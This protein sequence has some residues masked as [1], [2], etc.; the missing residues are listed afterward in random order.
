MLSARVARNRSLVLDVRSE[1][2][3]AAVAAAPLDRTAIPAE[4]RG[5]T[6]ERTPV[7]VLQIA[8]PWFTVPPSG[9]GGVET[10]VALLSDGLVAAGHEVELLASGGSRTTAKLRSVYERPPSELLGDVATDLG[11]VLDAY[12]DP[13]DVDLI[14]DHSGLIGP[15]LG[16][17]VGGVQVVHT[18]HGPWTDA[19]RHIYGRLA[20]RI[21][22]VAISNDQARRRPDGMPIAGMVHNTISLEHHP[23]VEERGDYLLWVGRA[24]RDK[25]PVDAIEVARRLGRPL[26]MAMKVNEAAEHVYYREVI[27]PAMIGVDVEVR[28]NVPLHAK[29]ALMGRASCLLFPI[30]WPEPFGLVMIESMACGTPVVAF[31]NGAAPEIIADGRT[32][33]LVPEGDID[34]FCTAVRASEMIHP[35]TCR[36]H[37]EEHFSMQRMV[38]GYL[39]VYER[40]LDRGPSA[41][42]GDATLNRAG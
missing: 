5:V 23:L 8:P 25:G 7:R 35:R 11:Q 3:P 24:N 4:R 38:D 21:G 16:A 26:V 14:H 28:F 32:G 12:L 15:A 2:V 34:A 1:G 40:L 19:N 36:E 22:L 6:V 18:L 33:F 30:R 10:V 9:Y 17:L 20:D 37:V 13:G 41:T 27:Q 29:A 31:A 42:A 39:D